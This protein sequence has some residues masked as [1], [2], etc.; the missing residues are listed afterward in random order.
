[1]KIYI[2]HI[3]NSTQIM[4]VHNA[5]CKWI[6]SQT[7]SRRK[8]FAQNYY[9]QTFP[10]KPRRRHKETQCLYIQPLG[11]FNFNTVIQQYLLTPTHACMRAHTHT[12]TVNIIISATASTN[13]MAKQI[14]VAIKEMSFQRSLERLNRITV[15]DASR[16]GIPEVS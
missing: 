8:K 16:R 6:L 4:H 5:R 10:G 11:K 2:L 15:P 13:I 9:P 3:K 7:K 1:M 14:L 12:Y